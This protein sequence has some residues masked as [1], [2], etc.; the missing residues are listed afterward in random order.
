MELNNGILV[1]VVISLLALLALGIYQAVKTSEKYRGGPKTIDD[2]RNNLIDSR[3]FMYTSE[4]R[5]LYDE[6][7]AAF[8]H[9]TNVMTSGKNVVPQYIPLAT[10]FIKRVTG[11]RRPKVNAKSLKKTIF[12]VYSGIKY[13]GHHQ[14]GLMLLAG[15]NIPPIG[16]PSGLVRR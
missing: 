5:R 14:N 7:L 16:Q 4:S 12:R 15:L 1:F 3:K 9:A 6:W 11:K 13:N 10:A 8:K 2:I